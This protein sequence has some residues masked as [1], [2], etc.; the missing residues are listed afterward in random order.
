[1]TYK[2]TFQDRAAQAAEAKQKALEQYR[3]KPP[4]D[5]KAAAERLA[6]GQ[7]REAAKAEKTAA[8]KAEREAAESA[9]A[10]D[11]EAKAAAEVTAAEMQGERLSA[12]SEARSDAAIRELKGSAPTEPVDDVLSPISGDDSDPTPQG[13]PVDDV[14][15]PL[16]GEN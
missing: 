12:Y 16:G 3:A 5:E 15:S 14:L 10:A 9:A 4:L 6:A 11:A 7:Q 8:K 1:M 2:S 13:D